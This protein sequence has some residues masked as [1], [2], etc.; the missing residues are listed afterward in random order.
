MTEILGPDSRDMIVP[1]IE[2]KNTGE[3]KSQRMFRSVLNL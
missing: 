3:N 1:F 2:G